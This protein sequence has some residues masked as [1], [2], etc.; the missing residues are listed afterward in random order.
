MA[1]IVIVGAG[2][3]GY[4]VAASLREA[5]YAGPINLFE[6]ETGLPYQ[7]PPL[8]KECLK[9][10]EVELA[11]RPAAFYA[12]QAIALHA[13]CAVTGIDR[14]ARRVT[15]SDGGALPYDHLVLATGTRA[16]RLDVPG[17][18]AEG[19][20]EIRTRADS[21]GIRAAL[22]SARAVV[23]IG[24]GFLGLEAAS[25]ARSLGAAVQV[26]ELW[27]RAMGRAV[28]REIS[29]FFTAHHR[30]AGI[31]FAFGVAVE[32]IE[33]QE[34]RA[35][36]V[37]AGGVRYPADLV[38]VSIGV[39]PETALAEAAGLAVENGVAVDAFLATDDPH[40]SAIGDCA[41]YPSPW[42]G[43][44]TRLES[45]QNAVDHARCLAARLTG[46]P[47]PYAAVPWFWSEQGSLRLQIAGLTAA[48]ERFLRIGAPEAPQFSVACFQGER[49]VGVE[50]VN[51]AGDHIAARK[52]LAAGRSPTPEQVAT[53][54]FDLRKFLTSGGV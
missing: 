26:I 28:S 42:T 9:G 44:R 25:V 27:P 29:D 18:D 40:I 33:T 11:F 54:G 51:K 15:L 23:V 7:R 17:R 47:A 41:S 46:T 31:G 8:S 34:G 21:E 45:V 43:G 52:L 6:A 20:F 13:G 39:V 36:A 19:V 24:A 48:A 12:Q 3:A 16:R 30:E 37:L 1:G 38:L 53:P 14:A 32:A 49:C 50:S 10:A 4:Q 35:V 22:P 2:Q 5:G